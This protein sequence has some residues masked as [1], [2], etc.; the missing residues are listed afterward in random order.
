MR[1]SN[2]LRQQKMEIQIL[3]RK[4]HEH[5]LQDKRRQQPDSTENVKTGKT[6]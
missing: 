3:S 1:H 2:Q 6:E 4:R 5:E